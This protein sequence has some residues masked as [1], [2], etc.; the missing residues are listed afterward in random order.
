MYSK[1]CPR[2]E[3]IAGE[4][5]VPYDNVHDPYTVTETPTSWDLSVPPQSRFKRAEKMNPGTPELYPLCGCLSRIFFPADFAS[6]GP[7]PPP[8]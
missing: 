7:C 8:S 5:P 4:D 1:T 3:L 6:P 2:Q